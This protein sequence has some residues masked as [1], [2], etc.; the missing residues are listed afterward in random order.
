M[1]QGLAAGWWPSGDRITVPTW[2]ALLP[3]TLTTYGALVDALA[4]RVTGEPLPAVETAAVLTFLGMTPTSP[5]HADDPAV[6]WDLG[7]TVALLLDSP[8]HQLR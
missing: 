2:S 3:S 7:R 5:V 8:N 6:S 1:H 4:T